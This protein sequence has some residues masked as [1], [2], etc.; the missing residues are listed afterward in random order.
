MSFFRGEIPSFWGSKHQGT[1]ALRKEKKK[2]ITLIFW[3]G[4]S[5]IR[6]LCFLRTSP[7]T[8]VG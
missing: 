5:L 1:K 6:R 8:T 3:G 4:F 2:K 7:K